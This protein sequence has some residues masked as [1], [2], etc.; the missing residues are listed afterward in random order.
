MLYDVANRQLSRR[1]AAFV[2]VFYRVGFRVCVRVGVRKGLALGRGQ[3]CKCCA[4]ARARPISWLAGWFR[5][6]EVVNRRAEP[7]AELL[8]DAQPV[9]L[10]YSELLRKRQEEEDAS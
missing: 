2:A 9:E 3:L 10:A 4:L 1:Y 5:S 6:A 8:H 7:A